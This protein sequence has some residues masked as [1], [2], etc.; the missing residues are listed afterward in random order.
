METGTVKREG[1]TRGAAEAEDV[2]A[3]TGEATLSCVDV[4]GG[5]LEVDGRKG[6]GDGSE[7]AAEDEDSASGDSLNSTGLV[8]GVACTLVISLARPQ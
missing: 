2:F 1:G 4:G 6:T 5:V 3:I 7:G 8:R